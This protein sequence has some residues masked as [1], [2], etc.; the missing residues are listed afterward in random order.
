MLV[1]MSKMKKESHEK[2]YMKVWLL[3]SRLVKVNLANGADS[4]LAHGY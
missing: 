2:S 1:N 4:G 3:R